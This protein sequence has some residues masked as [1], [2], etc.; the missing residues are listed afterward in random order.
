M[1]NKTIGIEAITVM[2]LLI[3]FAFVVFLVIDAGSNA[4][5]SIM[6]DKQSTVGARV[7]YSYISMKVKQNDTT[8]AVSVEQTEYGDTL[9][10]ES[11]DFATFIFY[12]DGD[13]YECVAKADGAPKVSAA[14]KIT[15]IDGFSLEQSEHR[16]HIECIYDR[17]GEQ[18][19]IVKGVVGLRS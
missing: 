13:L 16:L 14:N 18:Q 12:S 3:V 8:G 6:H 2:L 19:D 4:F 17:D 1:R 9:R 5:E 10:I 7:A 11:G 15:K